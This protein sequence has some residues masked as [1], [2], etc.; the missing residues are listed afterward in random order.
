MDFPI[1]LIEAETDKI[2]WTGPA[3]ELIEQNQDDEDFVRLVSN[4]RDIARYNAGVSGAY[5]IERI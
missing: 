2:I 3:A 4:M 5:V 1:N